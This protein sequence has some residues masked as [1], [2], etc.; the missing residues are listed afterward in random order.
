MKGIVPPLCRDCGKPESL[1]VGIGYFCPRRRCPGNNLTDLQRLERMEKALWGA[2]AQD[3]GG[4][5]Q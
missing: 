5:H 4:F 3:T 2:E 1:A